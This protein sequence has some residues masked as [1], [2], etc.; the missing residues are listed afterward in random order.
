MARDS[1]GHVVKVEFFADGEKIGEQLA[2]NLTLEPA[3][4]ESSAFSFVWL[5]AG[6]GRHVLHAVAVDDDGAGGGSQEVP[7]LVLGAA[8]PPVVRIVA[9]DPL[10]AERPEGS[11]PNPATF[12][13]Y[14]TGS[15]ANELIVFYSLHGTAE[16]GTDYAELS[17]QVL[18]PAGRQSARITVAPVNDDLPER[19]ETV[20][21]RL[22][23]SPA[24]SPVEPYRVGW[25]HRA[26]AV[27][28]DNDEPTPPVVEPLP[29]RVFHLCLPGEPGM[30][31]RLE[32]SDN[33]VHWLPL[34][35]VICEDGRVHFA[36]LVQ[37]VGHRFYRLRPV[38]VEAVD[39]DD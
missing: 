6:V 12:K 17:G 31:Y 34:R 32:A 22:E 10:A 18:I 5:G 21:V 36:D 14:R 27:I 37:D 24:L 38:V 35:D 25:P 13:V 23:P 16:P 11:P 29:D 30:P 26:C 3:N 9:T 1:D 33:L 39:L 4:L 15:L 20:I 28:V 2:S 7:I 19:I 8:E